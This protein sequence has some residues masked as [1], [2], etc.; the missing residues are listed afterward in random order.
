MKTNSTTDQRPSIEGAIVGIIVCLLACLAL[1]STTAV[2]I[3]PPLDK[4]ELYT[5]LAVVIM[6]PVAYIGIRYRI[7]SERQARISEIRREHVH[8]RK[9]IKKTS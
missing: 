7:R 4:D 5:V 8:H 2:F 6:I 1:I 9:F 3:M